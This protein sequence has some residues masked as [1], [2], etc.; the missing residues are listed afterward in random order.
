MGRSAPH[1]FGLL[2]AHRRGLKSGG[3]LH[4][5]Q[6]QQLEHV[7]LDHVAQQAG[8]FVVSAPILHPQL[9]RHGDL[10]VVNVAAI[11]EGF[12][13]AVGEPEHQQVLHRLFPQVV[14]DAIN[15]VFLENAGDGLVQFAARFPGFARRVFPG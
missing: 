3:R 11:P 2:I 15:L 9:F 7:I 1:D 14:I 12:E 5:H 8:L 10:H 4:G 6:A 13:N